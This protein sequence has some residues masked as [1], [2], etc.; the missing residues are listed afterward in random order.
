MC[1]LT[2]TEQTEEVITNNLPTRG[3]KIVVNLI[4]VA[5]ALFSYPLPYFAAA[6]LLEH[7]YFRERPKT[8]FPSCYYI[9][10]ELR[11]W[12]LAARIALVLSTMLMAVS[13][14]YFA[15]LMGL[16][17]SFTGKCSV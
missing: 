9:D 11:V 8:L 7:Q 14:P 2:W 16:I 10:G 15:L 12:G 13:I 6:A 3:F 5:K 17:G 1:F 4:L